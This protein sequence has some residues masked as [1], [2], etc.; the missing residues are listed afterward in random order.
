M[1]DYIKLLEEE[2]IINA[3]SAN[4]ISQKAYLKNQFEFFGMTAP[5]RREIQ[6]P[7]LVKAYL[8]PKKELEGLVKEL[9]QKPQ[10]EYQHFALELT[11]KYVNQMEMKDIELFEFMVINKAIGWILRDYSRIDS[12]WVMSYCEKTKLSNLSRR[13]ALRLINKP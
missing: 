11:Y 10:R 2:F 12:N 9:W 7:F 8:P 5:L 6:K 3:N 1:K 13:E 4:A